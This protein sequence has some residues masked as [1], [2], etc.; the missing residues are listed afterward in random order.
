[1]DTPRETLLLG[2]AEVLPQ[3]PFTAREHTAR[4]LGVVAA[5]LA[6]VIEVLDDIDRGHRVVAPF[7]KLVW[8]VDGLTHRVL[9][10]DEDRLRSHPGL[11][12]VGFFGERHLELDPSP[13]EDANTEIV[14]DFVDYPGILAYGSIEVGGGRWANLVLHDDPSDRDHWRGNPRHARAVRVLSPMHYKNVRIHNARLSGPLSNHPSLI[15]VRTKYF[16]YSGPEIWRAER[17]SV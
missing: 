17:P 9:I 3:R 10:T 13:L 2:S 15:D 14:A 11:C 4:D 1:M 16:D 8:R 12:V 6:D 5:M 7:Q